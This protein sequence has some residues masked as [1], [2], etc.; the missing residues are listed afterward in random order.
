MIFAPGLFRGKNVIV[1]GGGTGIGRTTALLLAELG[2]GVV[3]ASRKREHLD[4]TAEEL[5]AVAGAD[6]VVSQVCDIREP[7]DVASLMTVALEKLGRVD[8]LVNNAGGQFPSRAEAITPRGWEA[9]IRNNLNGTFYVTREAANRCFIPQ[10]AGKI[11]NVIVNIYRGNP[12]M[13]HTGAARAGVASLAM[14]LAVEWA[15]YGI[16][17]NSVAA[18]IIQSSGSDRYP[19]ELIERFKQKTPLGR[20]GTVDEVAA[21]IVYLLSPAADYVTG[22]TLYVDGGARLGTDGWPMPELGL[23]PS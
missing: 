7:D 9:V 12:G 15:E 23:P 4:P 17:V 18:G 5:V 8:L 19:P 3:I 2:A 16:C 11:V 1:T 6:K 21:A 13:S 10:R 20:M 14:S 22:S